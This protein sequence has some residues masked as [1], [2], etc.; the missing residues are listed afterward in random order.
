[1]KEL[2]QQDEKISYN[3]IIQD[4]KIH[5]ID[6]KDIGEK[7]K[8]MLIDFLKEVE[9]L[10]EYYNTYAYNFIKGI[11]EMNKNIIK[12]KYILSTN[13]ICFLYHILLHTKYLSDV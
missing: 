13:N 8:I 1:M 7:L 6:N 9:E 2:S 5:C 3:T 12:N 4:F 11:V 10:E